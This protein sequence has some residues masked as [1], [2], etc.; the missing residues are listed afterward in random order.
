MIKIEGHEYG[1]VKNHKKGFY[2]SIT[3]KKNI[4]N[5]FIILTAIYCLILQ[6]ISIIRLSSIVDCM[7]NSEYQFPKQIQQMSKHISMNYLTSEN[8]I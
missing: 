7:P 4:D 6:H 5:L 2:L 8:Y 1:R 3:N